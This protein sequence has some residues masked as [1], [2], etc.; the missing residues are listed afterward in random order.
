MRCIQS[1][2]CREPES[3]RSCPLFRARQ[4]ISDPGTFGDVDQLV[5]G[6]W[7]LNCWQTGKWKNGEM[8]MTRCG[9]RLH[10]IRQSRESI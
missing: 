3:A 9:Q 1:S 6:C 5:L 8:E 4:E 10:E 2:R 7:T